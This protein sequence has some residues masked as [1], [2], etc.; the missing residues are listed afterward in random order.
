[1]SVVGFGVVIYVNDFWR[2]HMSLGIGMLIGMTAVSLYVL[3]C[4]CST[5][6]RAPRR[7]TRQ[8]PL[9]VHGEPRAAHAAERHHRHGGS[10]ARH[11]AQP[12][13]GRHAAELCGP[14]A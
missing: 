10:A 4:A 9:R 7:R 2:Q 6:W 5:P 12:R 1:M 13:A 14:R 11:E 3:A 8:A